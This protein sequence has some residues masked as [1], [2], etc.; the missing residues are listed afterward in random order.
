MDNLTPQTFPDQIIR[1]PKKG[2][3]PQT[4]VNW[5][6]S[7]AD[8]VTLLLTFL[9]LLISVTSLEPHTPFTR[10]EG[11]LS[12]QP[13]AAVNL[14]DGVL[15]FSDAGLLAPVVEL[16]ENIDRLP[17]DIMLDQREIKDALFQ[18]DPVK[19]PDFQE[20]QA[21]VDEG[22][23]IF[24]DNRGL[25]VQ[26]D[27]SL[28]F[29]EGGTTLFP[30]NLPL[31]QRMAVF[32]NSMGLLLSVEGH[33]NPQSLLEGGTGPISYELS[34]RRAKVVMEYLASL[35][36]DENRF[37]IGGHGGSRPR[38]ADPEAAWENSRLEIVIYK[39][40]PSSWSG[41]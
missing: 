28:L 10:P 35:G 3:G 15:L 32:L 22:I 39:P 40:E 34:L 17:E 20:L 25:V 14:G 1:R 5:L 37:R 36:V 18:L 16:A 19:T 21:A 38:T 8:L 12:E 2:P 41:R 27:R 33:T 11:E 13:E 4:K 30:D 9:V 7:F 23:S 31:L 24:R 29:P 6:T 26:W